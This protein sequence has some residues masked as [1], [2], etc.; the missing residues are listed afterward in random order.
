MSETYCF[1]CL[2]RILCSSHYHYLCLECAQLEYAAWFG[3]P[4]HEE[5][6]KDD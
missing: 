5:T 1:V 3:G 6:P 4:A 2:E